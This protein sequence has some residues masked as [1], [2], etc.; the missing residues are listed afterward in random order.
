MSAAPTRRLGVASATLATFRQVGMVTSF[1]LA[2]AVAAATMPPRAIASLFLGTNEFLTRAVAADFTHGITT[3]FWVSV[4]I[5]L[6]AF[7][8]ILAG[9]ES[10]EARRGTAP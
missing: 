2:L 10:R 8:L 4:A 3:A 7:F 1:A 5:V 6:V 9:G